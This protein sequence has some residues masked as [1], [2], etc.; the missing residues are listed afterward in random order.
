MGF[1]DALLAVA[2]SAAVEG[3]ILHRTVFPDTTFHTLCFAAFGVN[4]FLKFIVYDFLIYPFFLSSLRH[5]PH[6]P[7]RRPPIKMLGVYLL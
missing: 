7:V 5:L 2:V 3:F 1:G 4:A 6:V